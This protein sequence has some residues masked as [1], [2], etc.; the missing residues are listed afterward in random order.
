MSDDDWLYDAAAM[1]RAATLT[2]LERPNS[3]IRS[4]RLTVEVLGLMG[5]SARPVAV[6]AI[7][8]NAEARGLVDQ[9][10]PMDAWPSSAWSVGI[11]PTADDDGWPGHLVAQV[12]IPGWPGRTII[13]STSDQL[14]R[15]EHGIDYQSPTIFGIPPGRPW[16]PRDPIWL[17]DPDTGTSLCYTLMAPGDPNTLLWRSAPAWTEAPA[18]IT[19]L[20]HEVLRRLHDQGW[21]APNL[22]GT[23]AQ[24]TF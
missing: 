13:D 24:P 15:P 16:T 2:L 23:V 7:A 10:V 14:H 1:V 19:A 9:G 20:A 4:T 12:R 17:S 18:D 3:C 11:A 6:H 21:Q 22:A 8:F 5:L